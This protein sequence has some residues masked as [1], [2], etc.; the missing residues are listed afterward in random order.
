MIYVTFQK[1]GALVQWGRRSA[2]TTEIIG[3]IILGLPRR[4]RQAEAVKSDIRS[5][6]S[7]FNRSDN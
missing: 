3:R 5:S 1:G 6:L 7:I 2:F 4:N